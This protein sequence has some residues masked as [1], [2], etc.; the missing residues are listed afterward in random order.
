MVIGDKYVTMVI[1]MFVDDGSGVLAYNDEYGGDLD[2]EGVVMVPLA[3]A[4]SWYHNDY[5][6]EDDI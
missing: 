2:A 4:D 1:L 5:G 6:N 3:D